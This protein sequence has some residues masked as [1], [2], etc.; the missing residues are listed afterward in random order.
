MSNITGTFLFVTTSMSCPLPPKFCSYVTMISN[1]FIIIINEFFTN[2]TIV[3][4]LELFFFF[5]HDQI[6]M[7]VFIYYF[8]AKLIIFKNCFKKFI[9]SIFTSK[10]NYWLGKFIISTNELVSKTTRNVVLIL[11][12][13]RIFITFNAF[14]IT[15]DF[16]WNCYLF[17]IIFKLNFSFFKSYRLCTIKAQTNFLCSV[18]TFLLLKYCKQLLKKYFLFLLFFLWNINLSKS[19]IYI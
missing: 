7:E 14:W 15:L 18:N 6:F 9:I 10:N 5:T 2:P 12:W 19:L 11:F 3:T 1:F 4:W 17:K 13:V 16:E 8:F